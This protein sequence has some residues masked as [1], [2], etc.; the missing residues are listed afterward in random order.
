MS[1]VQYCDKEMDDK[2]VKKKCDS[3]IYK[4]LDNLPGIFRIKSL[5]DFYVEY[6]GFC[7]KKNGSI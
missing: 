6:N 4:N 7:W 5:S 3:W 2:A 1:K